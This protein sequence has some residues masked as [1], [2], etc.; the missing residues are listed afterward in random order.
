MKKFFEKYIIISFV[1]ILGLQ[2]CNV[3]DLDP[4]K[5]YGEN[6]VYASESNMDLY[7][8]DFYIL[9]YKNADI[10]RG[11]LI[12][13]DG[14]SDLIKYSWFN[15]Q[16]GIVNKFFYL[17][18]IINP[19]SNFRSNW[20]SYY[21]YIRQMNELFSDVNSGYASKLDKNFVDTRVAEVRFL[22]AFAYQELVLRHGGVIL[23][24]DENKVDGPKEKDKARSTEAECWDFIM[25]EYSKAIE[26][27]PESWPGEDLGRITKGA[28]YG[29][30][31][32]AALY[33]QRWQD[34]IE[35]CDA[36]LALGYALAEGDTYE[37]YY[38]IFTD[39][40]NKEL[41]LPVLY[42]QSSGNAGGK[43][44]NFNNNFCPPY[45]GHPFGVSVGAAASPTEE[46]ASMFDIKIGEEYKAFDWGQLAAYGNKPYDNREPRFYASILYNGAKW[47]GR[48]LELYPGGKDGFMDF[49]ITGQDNVH[50]TTTGYIFRKYMSDDNKL[51]FTN[52]LSGQYWIEMRLAEIYLIRSEAFAR[53]NNYSKAYENLNL[54]RTRVGLKG[55]PA[56][57][58]WDAYLQDLSKERV[59][60]LGLEGHRYFDLVR[61]GIAQKVMDGKRL[62]G[63]KINGTNYEVVECDTQDRRFPAKYNIFP[64]PY[65]EIKNNT[66]CEQNEVWK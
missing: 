61:W 56:K 37:K 63:V 10:G 38:K 5:W 50:K 17:D 31:A 58:D 23:R 65:S 60:E 48:S 34:A 9:L 47:K 57:S 24:I 25:N 20:D 16:G 59:C 45:D 41:I 11:D 21:T 26:A 43:Q 18:N 53:L 30:K 36:V 51:N 54:I 46:Y 28:A 6:V 66:L 44:H 14:F 33:A 19:T 8:K 15:V 62:H 55:L 7:V 4:T 2:S 40:A 64:I 52:I 29:M 49:S 3:L 32:R 12:M 13:D 39:K 35:A 22:R 1:S 27:L 42:Q